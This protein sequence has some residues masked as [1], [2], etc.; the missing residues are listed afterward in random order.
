MMPFPKFLLR[1]VFA[2]PF[3]ASA[4]RL[5]AAGENLR[6]A[7]IVDMTAEGR[8]IA[9]P[10]VDH[11][12]TYV[13]VTIGY[14]EIGD[15]LVYYQGRPPPAEEVR[16]L[17]VKAL[18]DRGYREATAALPQPSLILVFRWG[19]IAPQV[20]FGRWVNHRE[21]LTY[22]L[23]DNWPEMI[24]DP[25]PKTQ[26]LV[27]DLYE[28]TNAGANPSA[29][30]YDHPVPIAEGAK[31]GARYYLMVSALDYAAHLRNRDV[32]LWR[33]HVSIN[34]WGH[35]LD[36]TLPSLIAAGVPFFG[37][38]TRKPEMVEAPVVPMGRVIV[39]TPKLVG[40]KD[41][42]TLPQTSTIE[43]QMQAQAARTL[44]SFAAGAQSAL[45][46]RAGQTLAGQVPSRDD[47]PR[48]PEA[49]R[50][51]SATGVV[52][53]PP[54]IVEARRKSTHWLYA[55]IPGH[56]I[57][58]ATTDD[59]TK[60]FAQVMFREERWL[61]EI[62]PRSLQA[63]N[64]VPTS[65]ILLTDDFRREFSGTAAELFRSKAGDK[66]LQL[67]STVSL[68]PQT[69][70]EVIP[71]VKLS[72]QDSMGAD[73]LLEP[74]KTNVALDPEFVFC[75]LGNRVPPLPP[76]F[77]V[78]VAGVWRDWVEVY[79]QNHASTFRYTPLFGGTFRLP[80]MSGLDAGDRAPL[81]IESMLKDPPADPHLRAL[82]ATESE[83]FVRWALDDMSGGRRK[84]LWR[85][86]DMASSQPA[87][88]AMFHECFGFGFEQALKDLDEFID[89]A[90]GSDLILVPLSP[91]ETPWIDPRSARASE[92]AR[93]LGDWQRKEIG[94]V[95][96]DYPHLAG[97]YAAQA[98]ATLNAAYDEESGDCDLLAARGLYACAVGDD[99]QAR[100][101]LE[102]AVAKKVRRPR[103][104]V[105]LA[106]I[107]LND[108]VNRP[109]GAHG[110]LGRA[111]VDSIIGL[112][113]A[114]R[115]LNPPQADGFLLA[116]K[117]WEAA[118]FVPSPADL[119]LLDEGLHYF[120]REGRLLLGTAQLYAAAGL[121]SRAVA[122]LDSGLQGV[123]D[124]R[125]REAFAYLRRHYASP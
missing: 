41:A 11:P 14:K 57:L 8:R 106:R 51:A 52:R 69:F 80:P 113:Q 58:S 36:E 24:S 81:P 17:L 5:P 6:V 125:L 124:P 50:D 4:V 47:Q 22:L 73:L 110:R 62:A 7:V 12:S 118:D 84:S 90:V 38:E 33:A 85:L 103:A 82:W 114:A 70:A 92:V 109:S 108:A 37:R 122:I 30:S 27:S 116:A 95:S 1:A 55:A 97:T 16:R 42:P 105:E 18:A 21:M 66:S 119:K 83:L 68:G 61:E 10:S 111:Q 44:D 56:E 91:V 87:S 76:W 75:Q 64:T 100:E 74:G 71:Q 121:R 13:P 32:L 43:D 3:F 53:L 28:A 88:E 40:G 107:R 99:R 25:S 96:R 67:V 78:G 48:A 9:P 117:T 59:D 34:Y 15:S 63:T 49:P 101:Y 60:R 112:L 102:T 2:V 98:G 46:G 26:E 35:S 29:G 86:A 104:Y 72:D 123:S 20:V 77:V 120:P 89:H 94:F 93:I 115:S 45:M 23:G 79:Y 31:R 39:G 19:S 54:F 65:L